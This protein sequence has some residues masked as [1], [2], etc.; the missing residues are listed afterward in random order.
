MEKKQSYLVISKYPLSC[1]VGIVII[2]FCWL[3]VLI[4]VILAPPSFT[5]LTNYL[6]SLGNSTYNPNGAVLYNISVIISGI[7]F[8]IFF[9]GLSIW[10]TDVFFDKV[11]IRGTQIIGSLLSIV[12]ILTGVFS[13]DF[14][15]QHV[16]WSIIAGILGFVVNVFLAVYIFIQKESNRK[17]S[18][19]IFILMG[20]YII[21]LFI[22]SPQHVLTEWVVRSVGDVSLILMI[23]NL[24][25]IFQERNRI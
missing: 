5:P 18:Y 16:F 15:P 2:V 1:M 23:Y 13:E 24:N 10:Y 17:I 12:L 7:L 3:A 19:T 21:L 25:H 20:S 9:V 14:K 6:S 8:Q 22:L 11:L 4:S